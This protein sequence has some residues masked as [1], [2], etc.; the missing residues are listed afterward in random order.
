MILVSFIESNDVQKL[1]TLF[2]V[3]G[4]GHLMPTVNLKPTFW[5]LPHVLLTLGKLFRC[6]V[7]RS[8]IGYVNFVHTLLQKK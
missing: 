3:I 2:E 5:K 1:I 7:L 8:F 6:S 4:Y